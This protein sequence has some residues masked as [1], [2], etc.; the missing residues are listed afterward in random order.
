[1]NSAEQLNTVENTLTVLINEHK[2]ILSE[3]SILS[4]LIQE[5]SVLPTKVLSVFKSIRGVLMADHHK[6][7]ETI[8]FKWMLNQNK[9]VDQDII[10]RVLKDHETLEVLLESINQQTENVSPASPANVT[11]TLK[12]D[13]GNF[14][15]LYRE[16]VELEEKFI[17]QIAKGLVTAWK[18]F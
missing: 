13:L 8:L 18:S 7:E 5:N 15:E 11:K 9:T 1:M 2:K 16:H 4:E 10:G 14:I 17:F 6:R 12:H 3:L